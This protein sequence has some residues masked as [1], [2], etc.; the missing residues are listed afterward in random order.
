MSSVNTVTGDANFS[1][2]KTA[3]TVGG[4]TQPSVARN[5]W[6]QQASI[7]KG[8]PQRFL[9]LIPQPY[10]STF[11][12]LELIDEAFYDSLGV[13]ISVYVTQPLCDSLNHISKRCIW[14]KLLCAFWLLWFKL[15]TSQVGM[16][17][18]VPL[19]L[20]IMTSNTAIAK[21][22]CQMDDFHWLRNGLATHGWICRLWVPARH[23]GFKLRFLSS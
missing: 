12:S 6:D 23:F 21:V 17:C 19:S 22:W 2:E 4:F 16:M 14:F 15:N 9:W 1:M 3:L 18:F 13:F 10:F 5:L 11:D 7:E 8:L 20:S